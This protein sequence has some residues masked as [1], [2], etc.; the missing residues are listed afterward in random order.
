MDYI[1]HKRVEAMEDAM[2]AEIKE[3]VEKKQEKSK[4]PDN[5]VL[6]REIKHLIQEGQIEDGS[7]FA[8]SLQSLARKG[9]SSLMSV[10]EASFDGVAFN[11]DTFDV[12][13]FLENAQAIV[14]ESK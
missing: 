6:M 5:L 3:E 8:K 7:D 13:F 11:K 1:D 14:N 2:Q 10:F 4:K 9:D 12:K